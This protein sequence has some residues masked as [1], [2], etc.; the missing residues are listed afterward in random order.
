MEQDANILYRISRTLTKRSFSV[1]FAEVSLVAL[2]FV[3]LIK[4]GHVGFESLILINKDQERER[5]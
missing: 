1:R 5:E 3:I 4:I 2:G